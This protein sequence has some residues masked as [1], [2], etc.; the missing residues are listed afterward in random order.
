MYAEQLCEKPSSNLPGNK[1]AMVQ[2][3]LA[4][5]LIKVYGISQVGYPI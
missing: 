4:A 2:R 5:R 1:T 3:R